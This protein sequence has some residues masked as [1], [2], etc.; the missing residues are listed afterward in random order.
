[1]GRVVIDRIGRHGS[2]QANLVGDRTDV[3]QQGADFGPLTPDLLERKHGPQA[4]EFL[5]LQLG[6]LLAGGEALG[7]RL[8][9]Q[10]CKL[11]FWIEELKMGRPAGHRQP[12]DP[13]DPLASWSRP[14]G[15]G[16]AQPS[17]LLHEAR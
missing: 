4:L 3:G 17:V 9:V 8:A 2:N 1:V 14:C 15:L 6:K 16:L 10:L 12:D 11:G 7:H 13:L 5:T